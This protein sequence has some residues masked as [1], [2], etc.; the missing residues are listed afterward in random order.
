VTPRQLA[1]TVG[2]GIYCASSWTW[3]IGM[4]LPHIL[5]D[6]YGWPGVIAFAVPNVLGC[7]GFGY[8]L[9]ARQSSALVE[10]HRRAMT[11]FSLITIAFHL[12]FVCMIWRWFVP[13]GA[14]DGWTLILA[15]AILLAGSTLLFGL[16][17]RWW[18]APA[19]I[20]YTISLVVWLCV[21][22]GSLSSIG[23]SGELS[24]AHLAW[25]APVMILGFLA[26]PYL[27][28]TFHRARQMTPS[29]HA[30]GVFGVTFA[31]MILLTCAYAGRIDGPL[32]GVIVVHFFAQAMMTCAVHLREMERSGDRSLLEPRRLRTVTI[33][34]IIGVMILSAASASRDV[35]IDVYLRM[36][37]FYGVLFP[38]YVVIVM[39]FS[40][41]TTRRRDSHR[42]V[43]LCILL[44]PL[45]EF[46]FLG[47][48]AWL[49][50]VAV[51][52]LLAIGVVRQKTARLRG[53]AQVDAGPSTDVTASRSTSSSY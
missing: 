53:D 46:G 18:P 28:L 13:P 14:L 36:F 50:T 2:W 15:P 37:F 3:C 51:G 39:P 34:L 5:L 31:A 32:F 30:F 23:W 26:C 6:R 33:V 44:A 45:C 38:A 21:G 12:L 48:P 43:F 52:V 9:N 27:D 1:L 7:A 20:A 49:L 29:R 10:R 47:S 4:F 41:A 24:L 8:V 17:D 22:G 16:P 25:T 19:G 11:W 40:D 35:M 42:V